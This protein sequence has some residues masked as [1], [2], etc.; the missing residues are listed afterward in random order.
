M[1]ARWVRA[2]SALSRRTLDGALVR[3][4]EGETVHLSAPAAALLRALD[5][6]RTA[7]EAAADLAAATGADPEVVR[8]DVD[9][10]L[11]DL[12]RRGVVEA[13]S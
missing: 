12:A 9:A 1:S 7:E 8:W 5:V 2:S 10:L 13:A 4:P 3:P 11:A 6:P